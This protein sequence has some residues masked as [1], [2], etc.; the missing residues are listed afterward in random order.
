MES[1]RTSTEIV[2]VK[3]EEWAGNAEGETFDDRLDRIEFRVSADPDT[4]YNAFEAGEGHN[5]NIPPALVEQAQADYETTLD[6]LFLGSYHFV[7]NDRNP[8]RSDEHTSELQSLMRISY[9]VFCS[10]KKNKDIDH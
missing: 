3:N 4:A 1:P 9:A 10:K 7:F 5:A 2:R 8:L 6:S